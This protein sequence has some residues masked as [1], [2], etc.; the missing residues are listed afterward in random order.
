MTCG[1]GSKSEN[2]VLFDIYGIGAVPQS[3]HSG[4]EYC[5]YLSILPH[6]FLNIQVNF[7]SRSVKKLCQNQLL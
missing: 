4:N 6:L 3:C 5:Y 2:T 7:I 1:G